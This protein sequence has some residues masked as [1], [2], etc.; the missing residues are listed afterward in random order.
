[1]L[2]PEEVTLPDAELSVY[3]Q[4]V[5]LSFSRLIIFWVTASS[6]G[7]GLTLFGGGFE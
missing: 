6:R 4:S 1:V 2:E 5:F 3:F 7:V